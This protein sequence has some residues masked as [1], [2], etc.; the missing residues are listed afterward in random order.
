MRTVWK[1]SKNRDFIVEKPDRQH[2]N[3]VIGV[4][5]TSKMTYRQLVALAMYWGKKSLYV[6]FPK[7]C[8]FSPV[9]RNYQAS[10]QTER[11]SSE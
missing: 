11:Q 6:A 10:P 2:R 8:N 5:V 1:G 3:E 9:T 4:T 7:L